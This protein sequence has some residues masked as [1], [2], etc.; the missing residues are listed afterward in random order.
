MSTLVLHNVNVQVIV[1]HLHALLGKGSAQ[2]FTQAEIHIP[3]VSGVA[4]A[5]DGGAGKTYVTLKG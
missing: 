1:G 3:V 4:P 2:I 5:E